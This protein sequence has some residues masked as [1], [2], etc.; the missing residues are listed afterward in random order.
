[1][2][3]FLMLTALVTACLMLLTGCCFHKEWYAATCETPKTCAECGETEGEALGHSWVEAGCETPKTCSV[4]KL[5]E[6]EALGH[7]W[8][9]ATTEAPKTCVACG[10]TEGERIVT[11]PRFT[12]AATRDIQ[13]VW[14]AELCVTAEEMGLDEGIIDQMVLELTIEMCNDGAMVV[15][16]QIPDEQGFMQKLIDAYVDVMYAEFEAMD[17]DREAADAAMMDVYGT[18][19]R[20]YLESA[21]GSISFNDI[22]SSIYSEMQ[23]GGVYYM[24]DGKLFSGYS[25]TSAMTEEA[26]TLSGNTLIIDSLSEEMGQEITFHRVTG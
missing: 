19:V 3:R 21:L 2:K 20:G 12:T 15:F 16:V 26:Y 14:V 5:T 7:S 10:L 6:G 24:E 23:L 9:D 17:M 4:C 11:D 18:D 8:E 22:L 25:W 1:M 13:G